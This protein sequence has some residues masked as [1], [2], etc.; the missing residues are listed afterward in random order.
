MFFAGQ[1][2]EGTPSVESAIVSGY[3]AA[4]QALARL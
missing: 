2:T 1:H 3:R 4:H